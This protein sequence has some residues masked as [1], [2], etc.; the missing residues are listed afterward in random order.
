MFRLILGILALPVSKQETQT[1]Q[2][3]AAITPLNILKEVYDKNRVSRTI[4]KV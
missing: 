1:F 2:K 4:F 3:K